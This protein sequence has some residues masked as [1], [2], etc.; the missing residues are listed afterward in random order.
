MIFL[1]SLIFN[2]CYATITLFHSTLGLMVAPLPQRFTRTVIIAWCYEVMWLLRIICGVECRYE[3]LEHIPPGSA[4]IA[5]KHQSALDIPLMLRA[6]PNAAFVLKRELFWI[7]LAGWCMWRMGMIAIDRS[8]GTKAM[9]KMLRLAAHYASVKRPIIIF[10]EGTRT[11]PGAP[12]NYQPGILALQRH[13]KLPTIPVA[14]NSGTVWGKNAFMKY[15]GKVV[16]SF[17]PSIPADFNSKQFLGEL[18][19]RIED[20]CKQL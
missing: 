13:L 9:K 14:L 18:E 7:P 11:A 17:L 19:R 10:P 4:L 2:I 1:R 12:G 16:V 6:F 3:G 20:R 8:R 15:P 5:A